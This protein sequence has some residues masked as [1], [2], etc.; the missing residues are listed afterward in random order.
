MNLAQIRAALRFDS[1]VWRRFAELGC[2]YG[3]EWWKR[4]SPPV[5]AGII[6]AIAWKR[7][8]AVLRNQRQVR[9]PRG[10]LR[11]RRDAY[12]VFAEFARTVT[13][14]LEQWGPHPP[15]FSLA[16]PDPELFQ[17]ALAEH[18]GLIVPTAHFGGA[19]IGARFLSDLG[20]PVNLVVAP[21]PN[22]TTREFMHR[23]RT[24]YGFNVIYSGR[25][26][27]GALPLLQALRR[28]EVVG[29]QID[30]WDSLPGAEG[31][32]FCG[33][34]APFR[35]GPFV[36]G[37]IARAPLIPVFTVRTGIRRYELRIA[38]RFD[39]ITAADTTAAFN[40][41]VRFY[42]RLVRERPWQWMQ[43]EDVWPSVPAVPTSVRH[44]E[45]EPRRSLR[46]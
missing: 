35:I 20:R 36:L 5:I 38:G 28:D 44:E 11:E 26:V 16:V 1:G 22:P 27:F 43:F 23:L 18:R 45:P 39:P 41:T 25:S 2:V 12:R 6:F 42:E 7:R 13:E 31:I 3:P 15:P 19:E 29:L 10:W 34:P 8:A 17:A 30:P 4:G 14:S 21:E 37:R 9:G 32:E 46:R 40:A 24:R 33:R